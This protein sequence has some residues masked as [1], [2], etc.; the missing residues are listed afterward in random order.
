MAWKAQHKRTAIWIELSC[1][2]CCCCVQELFFFHPLSPGSC[3]FLPH[4][5]RIYNA[6]VEFIREKYWEVSTGSTTK[7]VYPCHAPAGFHVTSPASC[8]AVHTE[9]SFHSLLTHIHRSCLI[10]PAL[11]RPRSCCCSLTTRR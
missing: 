9:P 10:E 4:G 6:M 8:T 11:P 5:A 1:C 7:R 2:P 3:F